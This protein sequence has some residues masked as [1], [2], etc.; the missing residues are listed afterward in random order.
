MTI[1]ENSLELLKKFEN[2]ANESTNNVFYDDLMGTNDDETTTTKSNNTDSASGRSGTGSDKLASGGGSVASGGSQD[3]LRRIKN[4]GHHRN[5]KKKKSSN[6]T[7][8]DE[9]IDLNSF[10]LASS[11]G[12][13]SNIF[14]FSNGTVN[15]RYSLVSNQNGSLSDK[16]I[17]FKRASNVNS[18]NVFYGPT[19]EEES[20]LTS[21]LNNEVS[22]NGNGVNANSTIF[23]SK[24]G[25]SVL[26][27]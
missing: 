23:F 2:D 11:V 3:Q 19:L 17:T 20:S 13:T 22:K 27:L 5:K 1:N 4:N 6:N 15:N 7:M 12:D 25:K 26:S 10:E 8:P 16:V 18:N 14:A 9:G 21:F 24:K